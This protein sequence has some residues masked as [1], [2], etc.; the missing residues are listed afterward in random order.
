MQPD[1]FLLYRDTG[2]HGSD[3][4]LAV[5]VAMIN[6]ASADYGDV[7]TRATV[8]THTGQPSAG[9]F[10]Y[11]AVVEPV[12]TPMV[13]RGLENCP[14]GARCIP[15]T[16]FYVIERPARLLD[17]PGGSSRSEYLSFLLT[18]ENCNGSSNYCRQFDGFDAAVQALRLQPDPRIRV[19][20]Q[21]H[22][23][24]DHEVQCRLPQ[25]SADRDAIFDYLT[26]KGWAMPACEIEHDGPRA[27]A[28]SGL[29][30]SI[31]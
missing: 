10:D 9:A 6:A 20:L 7:V 21:F 3:L 18:S 28:P 22:F 11:E 29:K 5:P 2:P 12:V 27:A 16:G 23:D 8:L 25:A 4:Y 15:A 30:G 24:G 13:E 26:T 19:H 1:H 17:V 14:Q 31:Q